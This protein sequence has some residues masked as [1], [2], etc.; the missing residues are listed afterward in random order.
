MVLRALAGRTAPTLLR[1][2]PL[3]AIAT[4]VGWLHWPSWP[5]VAAFTAAIL[6]ALVLSTSLSVLMTI[7]MLWT[8]SGVG[9]SRFLAALT[10]F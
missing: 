6:G 3:V 10:L 5:Q 9:V 8:V 7:S 2:A 4:V 1:A